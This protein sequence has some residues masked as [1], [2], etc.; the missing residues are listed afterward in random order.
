MHVV[1]AVYKN[2]DVA[3]LSPKH[4]GVPDASTKTLC[5]KRMLPALG[6]IASSVYAKI[7]FA[8]HVRP[9]ILVLGQ[10]LDVVE[11]MRTRAYV[12]QIG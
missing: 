10:D 9:G 6:R 7:K 1:V 11:C 8:E 4:R 3:L 12:T 5:A 2:H